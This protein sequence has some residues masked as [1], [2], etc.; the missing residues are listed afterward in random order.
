[1]DEF[2]EVGLTA[3]ASDLVKSSRPSE[4][5]VNTEYLANQIVRFSYYQDFFVFNHRQCTPG[6]T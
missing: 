2:K 3:I 1:M 5:P 4:A 6:G